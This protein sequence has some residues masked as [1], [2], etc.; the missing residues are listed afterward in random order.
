MGSGTG[1]SESV[2]MVIEESAISRRY[3]TCIF[4]MHHR[5]SRNAHPMTTDAPHETLSLFH[6]PED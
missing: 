6:D 3:A 5:V 4:S 1:T 2:L